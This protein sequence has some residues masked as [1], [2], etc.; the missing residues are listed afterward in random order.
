[1]EY[2]Q[3]DKAALQEKLAQIKEK[4]AEIQQMHLN[5]NMARGKP[6]ADQLA[7]SDGLFTAIDADSPMKGEDG[8]EIR[9]YGVLTGLGELKQIFADLLGVPKK[10]VILGGSSSLNLMFDYIS[11][12]MTHGVCGGAPWFG[13]KIKFLCPVPGY[14]RHFGILEYFGIE[15]IPVDMSASG[16]DMDQIE[17]YVRDSQVKGMFC[18]PKYS[19]PGGI[20]FSDET[21]ERIAKLQ[22]AAD[23]FRIIWDNAYAIHDVSD[24]PDT[25]REIFSACKQFGTEDHIIEVASFAKVTFPG[26]C[27][28]CIVASDRNLAQIEKRLS[29]QIINYDKINQM[30]HVAYFKDADGVLAHMKKHAAIL[31]PK[32][33]VVLNAFAKELDG[34]GI[35]AWT[36]P[37]GGYFISLDVLDG[38]AKRVVSLCKDAGLILTGAG[39]TYPLKNDPRDRNIRI[40]PTF[41]STEEL[42]QALDVLCLCV[43]YACIEKIL[44]A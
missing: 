40:A 4:Y 41:P 5:L 9:N 8:M 18:V 44:N 35:A 30:R 23:D 25:L 37:N 21:V 1:M 34:K 24:T 26:A 39:A 28:S 2:R 14:D 42:R 27:V 38:C 12:C 6:G 10:N 43:E 3:M 32:F 11:Q 15:M 16:P 33:D 29:Y 36:K 7:L 19:N 13:Q 17:A 31:K 20:T 22:P